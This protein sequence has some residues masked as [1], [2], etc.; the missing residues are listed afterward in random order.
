MP[1]SHTEARAAPFRLGIHA[2]SFFEESLRELDCLSADPLYREDDEDSK[3]S[4][5]MSSPR[6]GQ[7]LA[8]VW[9]IFSQAAKLPDRLA[10]LR[11]C[12]SIDLRTL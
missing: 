11:S 9:H 7:A 1:K 6:V 3:K 4:D 8:L 12:N 2:L 5:L 10:A